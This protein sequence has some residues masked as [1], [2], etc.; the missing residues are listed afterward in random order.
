MTY[1][2]NGVQPYTLNDLKKDF[3][4]V[5][6][7]KKSFANESFRAEYGIT[8]V[9]ASELPPTNVVPTDPNPVPA[10]H[11]A[12]PGEPEFVDGEW[13][14]TW[15]YVEK[16][17]KGK[18]LEEYGDAT[19]QLEF[20]TENGLEA[21]QEK[22]AEIKARIPVSLTDGHYPLDRDDT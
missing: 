2:R 22:V 8:E 18:R 20:I 5:G 12:V 16:H 15:D 10:G 14:G 21:W 4:N 19:D 1:E 11:D 17:Y 9:S 13:R 6:F 3:P 7:P